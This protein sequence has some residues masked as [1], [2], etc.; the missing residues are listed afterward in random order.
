MKKQIKK[1]VLLAIIL[2][3][4]FMAFDLMC[5]WIN[6]EPFDF[7]GAAFQG[8]AMSV[9]FTLLQVYWDRKKK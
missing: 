2:V 8:A 9:G 5:Q 6:T 3:P 7:A 1:Y 4:N